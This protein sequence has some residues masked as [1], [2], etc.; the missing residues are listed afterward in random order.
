LKRAVILFLFLPLLISCRKTGSESNIL[1]TESNIEVIDFNLDDIISKGKI[2]GIV[3]NNST[4][5]FIYKGQTMGYE[6]ELLVNLAQYLNVDLELKVTSNLQEAADMLDRGEGDI[7]AFPLTVTK[8][9]RKRVLFTDY[10]YTIKM[11]L[12]Q[13]YPEGWNSMK[14]HEIEK[15]LIRNQVDLI[16]KE[17]HVRYRS[18]YLSRLRNLSDEIGGD[19]VIVEMDESNET[20][21]LIK[22]VANNEI[23]FTVAD[24][25]IAMVNATYYPNIDAKTP[26]SFPTQIAWAVRS[27]SPELRDTINL[28]LKRLKREPTFN[29]IYKK[30]FENTKASLSRRRSEFLS[31]GGGNISE[32]DEYLKEG[33]KELNWD[34]RLLA[35]QTYQESKFDPNVKS[36]AGAIGLMQL[37]PTTAKEYGAPNPYDPEQNIRGGVNYL[38]WLQSYWNPRLEQEE[39]RTKFILASY[40]VGLGHVLDAR[41]LTAKFKGDPDVWDQNVEK[42]LQLKS[43]PKYYNDP[44]VRSGYCR[45]D[46]PVKYVKEI[47]ARYKQYI[48]NFP[49]DEVVSQA[50]SLSANP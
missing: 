42:Y 40:N 39:E 33:A 1:D 47:L 38:K 26:V 14:A 7:I 50:D 10:Q 31:V 3:E 34:W 44:V 43:K 28:W 41:Q 18:S 12:V 45:G 15:Q 17:V 36:W 27:N 23:K 37:I 25:D 2:I 20:E 46:E 13:G 48:Q 4:G 32:Y 24:E 16:G 35:S 5:Y 8:E 49:A 6:Y 19:I 29:V 22:R 30:Y 11:V 21:D 9:R